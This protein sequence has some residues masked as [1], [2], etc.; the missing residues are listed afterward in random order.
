MISL[1]GNTRT[2]PQRKAPKAF[3]KQLKRIVVWQFDA[4]KH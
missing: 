3:G 4:P 2:K 1:V